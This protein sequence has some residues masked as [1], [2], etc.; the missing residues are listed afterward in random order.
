MRDRAF[1]RFQEKKKKQWAKK[2]GREWFSKEPS[3]KQIGQLAHTPKAC[4][5]W[6]CGNQR[7]SYGETLQEIRIKNKMKYDIIECD[8]F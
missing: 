8:G 2:A 5:C 3:A 7:K 4:S 1:R 6:M